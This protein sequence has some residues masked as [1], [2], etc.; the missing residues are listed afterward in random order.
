MPGSNAGLFLLQKIMD[1]WV[2]TNRNAR[3][4]R[5][6]RELAVMKGLQRED[7]GAVT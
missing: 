5:L 7:I 6:I 1:K 4:G 2:C 3:G